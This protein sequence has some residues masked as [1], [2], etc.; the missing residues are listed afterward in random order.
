MAIT[1][2]FNG[3]VLTI[4]LLTLLLS[5]TFAQQRLPVRVNEFP[6]KHV[7]VAAFDATTFPGVQTDGP[8]L[9]LTTFYPAGA[10]G[11]YGVSNIRNALKGGPINMTTLDANAVWPN[12]ANPVPPN[13]LSGTSDAYVLTAGGFFVSPTKATGDISLLDI[14]NMYTTGTIKT[15]ISETKSENFY[16]QAEWLDVDGDGHMDIIAARAY[17]SPINPLAKT[18]GALVWLVHSPVDA[19]EGGTWIERELTNETG[20]GVGFTLCDINGDGKTE[21][22]AAQFF[23]AQQ[24]SLWWCDGAHWSDCVGGV[25]V[26]TSIIDNGEDA[27]FFAVE[28]VDLDGDGKKELLATTNTANGKGAVFVYVQDANPNTASS[29]PQDVANITWT[30]HL[31]AD[32][33]KPTMPY[34]PGRGAPGKAASFSL[35]TSDTQKSILV[36][37]DDGGWVDLLVPR[38]DANVSSWEYDKYRVVNSTSTIGTP[39][40]MDVDGDGYADFAVPLFAEN[41]VALYTFNQQK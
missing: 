41:K 7:A 19:E 13:T 35:H 16:H 12:Q 18:Q 24:L 29:A 33:Y 17:K 21:V 39:A 15:T 25:G 26:H 36:C 27:P 30:K 6:L 8:A 20:P 3:N 40:I 5:C 10:D 14:T 11:V 28:W 32:G 34:L 38:L 37:A 9:L 31:I 22:V 1:S 4:L 2:I 23:D